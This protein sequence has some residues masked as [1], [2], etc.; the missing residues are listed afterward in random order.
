MGL[1]QIRL[2]LLSVTPFFDKLQ[3][4]PLQCL[5]NALFERV[6]KGVTTFAL[7]IFKRTKKYKF[8]D[9]LGSF[10]GSFSK[11]R[12]KWKYFSKIH[13]K[14]VF[15]PWYQ[16]KGNLKP[17]FLES[18]KENDEFAESKRKD[19]YFLNALET[20]CCRCAY[21]SCHKVFRKIRT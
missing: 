21:I 17:R 8:F 12:K 10:Y 1:A 2:T 4:P 18:P 11:T 6:C 5:H 7:P 13:V 3:T 16:C 19:F 14:I 9:I 20:W 15:L